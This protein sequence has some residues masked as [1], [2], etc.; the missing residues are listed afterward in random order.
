MRILDLFCGCGCGAVGYKKAIP[1]ATITGVDIQDMS[2]GYPFEFIQADV[3]E[4]TYEFLLDFDFIHASPPCQPYS[5]VTPAT[6][7]GN[8]PKLINSTRL[9][10]EAA[11]KPYV[12]E[13]VEGSGQELQP[14]IRIELNG[15]RRY[16]RCSFPV[17]ATH[18]MSSSYSSSMFSDRY[19]SKSEIGKSWGIDNE[20]LVL[21]KRKTMKQGIPP[22]MTHYLMTQYLEGKKQ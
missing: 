5:K 11:G 6:R 17:P 15:K 12:I 14:N 9:L 3:I 18:K 16:F 13:N 1:D 10:L 21:M 20:Y 19:S 2:S 22:V 4:L 7:R 8:T